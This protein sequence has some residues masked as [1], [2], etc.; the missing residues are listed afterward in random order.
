MSVRSPGD[1]EEVH[2]SPECAPSA[3]GPG[4][5]RPIAGERGIPSVN[6]VR[7]LQSRMS[8]VMAVGLMTTLGLG[9]LTWYYARVLTHPSR[10]VQSAQVLAKTGVQGEMSLPPLGPIPESLSHTAP[11]GDPVVTSPTSRAI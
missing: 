5:I 4:D 1:D 6:R 9:L 11:Q 8:S 2:G 10:A 7:S 3:D